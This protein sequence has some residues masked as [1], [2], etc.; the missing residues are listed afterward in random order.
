ALLAYLAALSMYYAILTSPGE[1]GNGTAVSLDPTELHDHPIMDTLAECRKLWRK[2]KDV[3]IP[4]P[5]ELIPKIETELPVSDEI[6]SHSTDITSKVN[7]QKLS[8]KQSAQ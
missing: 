1:A 7:K 5:S 4:D 2:L 8:K 3:K 6:S